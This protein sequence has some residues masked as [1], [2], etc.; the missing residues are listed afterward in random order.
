MSADSDRKWL[1]IAPIA[2]GV[3]V[4]G[5]AALSM[6]RSGSAPPEE[7]AK[8]SPQAESS[9]PRA[10]ALPSAVPPPPAPT[11]GQ[12]AGGEPS[13]ITWKVPGNWQSP[14]NSSPM[15]IATYRPPAAS[16]GEE[17]EMSVSRA[18]G[19]TDANIERWRGQFEGSGQERRVEKSVRG[20]KVTVVELGGT[21]VGGNMM[22]GAPST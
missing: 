7:P 19:T 8:L 1:R 20:L 4:L 21:Y 15:R 5:A 2:L 11:M 16:G 18:G 3:V 22:P 10:G 17:A 9:G 12:G 13:A 6:V 14:A